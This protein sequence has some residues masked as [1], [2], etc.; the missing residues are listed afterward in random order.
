M[1][2]SVVFWDVTQCRLVKHRRFGTTY[3][4]HFQGSSVIPVKH[5]RKRQ[6]SGK[7]QRK[8]TISETERMSRNV[9][10]YQRTLRNT[11]ERAK[12]SHSDCIFANAAC[13]VFPRQSQFHNCSTRTAPSGCTLSNSRPLSSGLQLPDLPQYFPQIENVKLKQITTRM[14]AHARTPRSYCVHTECYTDKNTGA[15][16]TSCFQYYQPCY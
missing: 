14:C 1:L 9:G 12:I 15:E 8:P 2:S 7:P 4:S 16:N 13:P 3:R 10:N 5:P 6:N 11:P